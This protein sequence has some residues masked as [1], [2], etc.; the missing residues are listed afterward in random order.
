MIV[1]PSG[2]IEPIIEDE[3]IRGRTMD[4]VEDVEDSRDSDSSVGDGLNVDSKMWRDGLRAGKWGI[5]DRTTG[6]REERWRYAR[7]ASGNLG[8]GIHTSLGS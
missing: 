1:S 6:R 2:G 7:N 5:A 3:G 4:N 8:T